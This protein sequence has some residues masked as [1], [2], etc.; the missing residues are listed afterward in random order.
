MAQTADPRADANLD[1][2]ERLAAAAYLAGRPDAAETWQRAY[3]ECMRLELRARAARCAFWLAQGLFSRGETAL[4]GGWIDRAEAALGDTDCVERGYLLL[5][6]A[7][8]HFER[9]EAGEALARFEMAAAL[10]ARFG[11]PD[12]AAFAAMGRGRVMVALEQ[13][14]AATVLLD[15]AMV[16]VCS[17]EVSPAMAGLVYCG[18][19]EA[20]QEMVDL[21]RAREWTGALSRW[22]EEQPDRVPYRGQCL[23]HRAEIMALHGDWARGIDEARDACERLSGEPAAGNAFYRLGE[24]HRL[25]GELAEADDAFRAASRAGRTPQPGLALLR[26][27]QG[28]PVV[29]QAA[30]RRVVE[31]TSAAVPRCLVLIPY[32]EI[33]LANGG[34]TEAR[35]AADEL[36][37]LAAQADRPVLRAYA[38]HAHAAVTLAEG[39]AG[40]AL[41]V[42]RTTW[43]IWRRLDMPYEAARVRVLVGLACRALGDNDGADMEFEAAGQEFE[44]LGAHTDR[45]QLDAVAAIGR[46][47]R[48]GDLTD[49]EVE[50]LALVA[51]G[52]TN[53]QIGT[54]LV[55]SEHTV[56]RHLQNI[57]AKLGVSSRTAA[58]SFLRELGPRRRGH[59]QI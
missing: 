55:V 54:A 52:M 40:A 56:A 46:A 47:H 38:A 1:D 34:V 24:L 29:A 35:V 4:G 21:R 28:Q 58:S 57:F 2:L 44:R 48:D 50:V 5:P 17:G 42:L 9:G 43:S 18:A 16:A 8:G 7:I 37:E 51:K 19:I 41:P 25:R 32:V 59:G 11:D 30:I 27:A 10:A 39:A 14:A 36:C 45:R 12:L 15:A 31:E 20:C 26:L 53:R 13:P 3:R 6:Q 49:R 23:V 22:C 33:A